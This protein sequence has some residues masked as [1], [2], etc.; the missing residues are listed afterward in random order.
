MRGSREH[1]ALLTRALRAASAESTVIPPLAIRR[2]SE[3][4]Q[5]RAYGVRLA[6]E[7]IAQ[8]MALEVASFDRERFMKDAGFG[9]VPR[10]AVEA[11]QQ[12]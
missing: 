10:A 9:P 2:Q 5:Q 1:Y 8:E 3:P 4:Y 11:G 12:R 6:A 7:A